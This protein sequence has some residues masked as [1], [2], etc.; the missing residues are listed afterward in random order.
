M[1][2][3]ARFDRDTAFHS[4][5]KVYKYM[6]KLLQFQQKVSAIK[7][8]AQNPFFKSK[9]F[10]INT[11]LAEVKPILSELGLVLLQPISF[12]ENKQV[13]SSEIFDAETGTRIASSSVVLPD[14]SDPQKLGSAITYFRRYSLQSLLSLEAEDD[15]GNATQNA[16][17]APKTRLEAPF[18][19]NTDKVPLPTEIPIKS[20]IKRCIVCGKEMKFVNAGVSKSTGKPY[21]SFWA[22]PDKC[23]QNL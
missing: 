1:W 10:D 15:D 18:E 5:P 12:W 3:E 22:C 21:N 20:E 6:K 13:V 7:R 16:P 23:R 9:Y 2:L 17:Q 11:L 14:I 8:D 19:S 4:D